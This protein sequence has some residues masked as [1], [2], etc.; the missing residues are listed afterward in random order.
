[1]NK[2]MKTFGICLAAV[3][4]MESIPANIFAG[5]D[6]SLT[7]EVQAASTEEQPETQMTAS[8]TPATEETQSIQESETVN[9]PAAAPAVEAQPET[10]SPILEDS[11]EADVPAA[12]AEDNYTDAE[13]NEGQDTGNFS[14]SS[15]S[16]S[17]EKE[18]REV[19]EQTLK[20]VKLSEEFGADLLAIARTQLGYEESK[21][22]III[23][24][25]GEELAYNRYAV[26]EGLDYGEWNVMFVEFCLEYAK[27]PVEAVPSDLDLEKWQ[28]L[29]EEQY[30]DAD[31]G[32]EPREGDLIFFYEAEENEEIPMDGEERKALKPCRVGIVSKEKDEDK[33]DGLAKI[34]VI[35]GDVDGKVAENEYF[36]SDPQI[37]AYVDMAQAQEDYDRLIHPENYETETETLAESEPDAESAD[38]EQEKT[39]EEEKEAKETGFSS[40]NLLVPAVD[41]SRYDVN[42][43]GSVD[44]ND[45]QW[46]YNKLTD[47]DGG[48]SGDG[49]ENSSENTAE[50]DLL[51]YD[52]NDDG[53]FNE[54]D[55]RCLTEYLGTKGE[56]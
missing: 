32:Y 52:L 19:W 56:Q 43:S 26:W 42:G 41:E 14:D 39:E 53:V 37:L 12:K 25:A 10:S 38:V 16:Y 6:V 44:I 46:L 36:W 54:E 30:L 27:I 21:T 40:G 48:I 28:T 3:L 34:S 31:D 50:E 22:D 8:E 29:L 45:A 35:E 23:S 49:S 18:S 20:E 33:E 9:T 13:V 51:I 11:A 17:E 5:E 7:A 4:S 47:M 15:E 55:V 24:E 2:K 1:M